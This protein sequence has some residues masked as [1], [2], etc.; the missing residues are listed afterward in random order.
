[1]QNIQAEITANAKKPKDINPVLALDAFQTRSDKIFHIL[2]YTLI[3]IVVL[4]VLL[5][6]VNVVA[7]SFSAANAINSGRVY[8]W[9]V[10][11]TS[12]RV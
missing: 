11:L 3:M 8:L 12:E 2:N 10:D 4:V 5:P 6:L 9:P 1:M 7:C